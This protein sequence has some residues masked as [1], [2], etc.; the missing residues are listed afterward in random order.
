[1]VATTPNTVSIEVE[2]AAQE[3]AKVSPQVVLM[4]LAAAAGAALRARA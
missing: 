2:P 4:G 1:V 3:I